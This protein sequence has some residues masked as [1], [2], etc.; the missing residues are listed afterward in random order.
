LG[1]S[2]PKGLKNW[3]IEIKKELIESKKVWE[4]IE[5]EDVPEGRR[6]IKCRWIFKIKRNEIL[7]L[8]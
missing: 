8:Y 1:S 4:T 2:R 6:T 5:K 7:G 3:R